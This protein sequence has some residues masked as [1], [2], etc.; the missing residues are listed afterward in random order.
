MGPK[1]ITAWVLGALLCLGG[2]FA[3][4]TAR[5]GDLSEYWN[6]TTFGPQVEA[7]PEWVRP[8]AGAQMMLDA[9]RV[10][11]QLIAAPLEPSPTNFAHAATI[12]LP[13]PD[14][15]FE[16]F[17]VLQSPVMAAELQARFPE[18]RTYLARGLDT[19]GASGRFDVTPRGLSAQI[20][21]PGGVVRI[22]PYVRG[23]DR[24][25]TSYFARDYAAVR[26][27][28][29]CG[30]SDGPG[31]ALDDLPTT[32]TGTPNVGDTR[33]VF[34][35]A[36]ATTAEYTA[37]Q[38]G[39]T[40]A[41]NAIVTLVNQLNGVYEK[42]A[43]IRFVLVASN[44]QIIYTDAQTD[45]YTN[46]NIVLMLEENQGALDAQ[47]GSGNY[48]IGHVFG[49]A[50]GGIASIG[51][52]CTLGFKARGVSA[53]PFAVT[54]PYTIQTFCH[55]VGHQFNARHT[56]N[57]VGGACVPSQRSTGDAYEPGS[58]STLM[59]YASFCAA[60][61]VSSAYGDLYLNTQSLT[62]INSYVAAAG[63]CATLEATGN[64]PPDLDAG[65][66]FSIPAATPFVLSAT[67]SDLDND[68]V[69]YCWEQRNLGPAQPLADGDTGVG[70]II[71]SRPATTTNTRSFP[72]LSAVLSGTPVAGDVSPTT[73]RTLTFRVTARDNRA[74]AGGVT[75]DD[76]SISVTTDAGPFKV[77]SPNTSVA[78]T[79]GTQTIT[80]DVLGTDVA[81]ISCATVR[82]LYSTNGGQTFPFVLA[83][84]V[85]NTGSA[86]VTIPQGPT[87]Q[88]RIRIEAEGN[89]FY[90]VSD[91]NFTVPCE[92][93][94]GV[95]A[96]ESYC[97]RVDVIWT[98]VPGATGYSVWRG[99]TS[100]P[101]SAALLGSTSAESFSDVTGVIGTTYHYFVSTVAPTCTSGLGTPDTGNRAT[102][103]PL[104]TVSATTALCTGINLA[105]PAYSNAV[106]YQVRR[107][108]SN[109][110][111]GATLIGSPSTP[112][113]ADT[114]AASGQAYFYFVRA[115]T[116]ACGFSPYAPSAQGLRQVLPAVPVDVS[117]S[118]L[119]NCDQIDLS[120]TAA[121]DATGYEVWRNTI[122]DS[123]SAV[124]I[125]A[126]SGTTY[127]DVSALPGTPYFY[128]VG[129]TNSCGPGALSASDPGER[130]QG[131]SFITHPQGVSLCP[132][133]DA[134]FS[135]SAGGTGPLSYQ[136]FVNDQPTGTNAPSLTLP[137]VSLPD[138]GKVVRCDVSNACGTVPSSTALLDVRVCGPDLFVDASAPPGGNGATWG[139]ALQRL[140]DALAYAATQPTI[141]TIRVAAGVYT[142]HAS[143]RDVS[144]SPRASLTIL[145]GYPIGGGLDES[146]DPR[147]HVVTLSGDLQG[148]DAAAFTNRLDNSRQVVRAAFP[149]VV[150]DGLTIR[151]GNADAPGTA[152]SG[153]AVSVTINGGLTVLSCTISDNQ[154]L[155]LGGG[156]HAVG[157]LA[158]ERSTI[159]LCAASQGGGLSIAGVAAVRNSTISGNSSTGLNPG[160]GGG[161]V[162][163][164][165][166]ADAELQHCTI[167]F[168][169]A[170]G[171][172]GGVQRAW[173][174]LTT[175]LCIISNNS[176]L[177][178]P[179]F[180][181]AVGSLGHNLVRN[182]A[183]CTQLVG[184]D[185]VGVEPRLGALSNNGGPTDSHA[186]GLY[187]KV[188]DAAAEP[189]G[190]PMD[191]RGF[192]RP[193][194]GL[195]G[196]P[197]A[198][199]LG[200]I[201]VSSQLP[202]CPAD[203]DD[204][205]QTN[206][207]DGG[208]DIG[209]LLYFLIIFEN[210]DPIADLD[211]GS[212]T[213][214]RDEGVDVS[215][216]LYFLVHF[217]L[218]C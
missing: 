139:S 117:A 4:G 91:V 121:S 11:E 65:P 85:P 7:L 15:R 79:P 28:W 166:G 115:Q 63:A 171:A 185:M 93:P 183:G 26:P 118:D 156:I 207:P 189:C 134:V 179:D 43:C 197:A 103:A 119:T 113:F 12:L 101:G 163:L 114:S 66:D 107:H 69:T 196:G 205:S 81:P 16:R 33:R 164:S 161:G 36:V 135:V 97:D 92:P 102:L 182:P 173:G 89:I 74:G 41:M 20:F 57:G 5:A 22:D 206:Y 62:R 120:W 90:D 86:A 168:N 108:T 3:P 133:E 177:E 61:N 184:S 35:L 29:A 73:T 181:G 77:T 87:T 38:G 45:P 21:T 217:E 214:T 53:S 176:A 32:R 60:D 13:M 191:Q 111:I 23:D 124:S 149:A 98:A 27:A 157:N 95:S 159:A 106:A 167:A 152:E 158:L 122:N 84:A 123:V 64:T 209:D 144:F 142:P 200:A 187:S 154:A 204:G 213:G 178:A 153:G 110:L 31:L 72:P 96:S 190:L 42:E 210:G 99:T 162:L 30:A 147:A 208:I 88:A 165:P 59:S 198:C 82:I 169:A 193:V 17:A 175:H 188:I 75:S 68:V 130:R 137:A 54:D 37:L 201:E 76:V 55:E 25:H 80:W 218:G 104:G 19:P 58:G 141:T 136:W 67:G 216:L 131:V 47:I 211:D 160:E 151:G 145:G 199:D 24:Y 146:R 192:P 109:S 71:R 105:W 112:S 6:S 78:W 116:S 132:G 83:S 39:P 44:D 52:V 128:F 14:G 129:A 203:L 18:L 150:L 194:A 34:R 202:P 195:L 180:A 127:A 138:A 40:Q 140:Q 126:P 50:N 170:A 10:R 143:D 174:A 51:V 212:L 70:P 48:D 46:E 56:F 155:K 49:T 1:T 8:R 125:A 2:L 172:G 9:Q 100:A 148:D 215:D 94:V 186:P